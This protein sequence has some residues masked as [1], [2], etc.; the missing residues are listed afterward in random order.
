MFYPVIKKSRLAKCMYNYGSVRK[1]LFSNFL[2]AKIVQKVH[3]NSD[4]LKKKK[5]DDN[6]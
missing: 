1:Q 5:F 2:K 4:Q 3:D 6:S